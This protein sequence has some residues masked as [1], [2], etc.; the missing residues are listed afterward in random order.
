M[1]EDENSTSTDVN[2]LFGDDPTP[3]EPEATEQEPEAEPELESEPESEPEAET[4]SESESEEEPEAETEEEEPD[5]TIA[6]IEI[7]GKE[8]KLDEQKVQN[9]AEQ[10]IK[11]VQLNKEL[12]VNRAKVDEALK[13]VENIRSGVDIDEA[14]KALG[15]NFDALIRD[16]VKDFI[17]RSTLSEKERELE[18][19]NKER[20]KLRKQIAEREERE[21]IELERAEGQKEAETII[22]SVNAAIAKVP[23]RFQKEIQIEVFAA[24]ERR[25]RN[26]GIRPSQQAIN[27]AVQNIYNR[28]YKT[29][30]TEEKAKLP[31]QSKAPKVTKNN[32]SPSTS[33]KKSVYNATD[34]SQLF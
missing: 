12:E 32:P 17:R 31:T 24:I 6:T 1:F 8:F 19:A 5:P 21:R 29:I 3:E 30:Q 18:D 34:Y 11:L 15:V 14:M 27:N 33:E 16:K 2:D 23:Q 13:Y 7:N 10:Y 20:E 28:K 25:L 26:G 9:L 4:E 22:S